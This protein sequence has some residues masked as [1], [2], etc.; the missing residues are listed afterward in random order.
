MTL[1]KTGIAA[2]SCIPLI[3]L[4]ALAALKANDADGNDIR[5][6]FAENRRASRSGIKQATFAF[7]PPTRDEILNMPSKDWANKLTADYPH[8]GAETR[9]D[10]IRLAGDL[11]QA[12]A[13]G[14][15]PQ[16]EEAD[17]YVE[18]IGILLAGAN[19]EA[20]PESR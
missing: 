9:V 1:S 6:P 5:A 2:I 10:V 4:A 20:S 3:A 15:D 16:G 19:L 18:T 13:E 8:L 17:T 12:V 14:L 7:Q 11:R